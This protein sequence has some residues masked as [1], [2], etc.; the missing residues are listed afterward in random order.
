MSFVSHRTRAHRQTRRRRLVRL[1]GPQRWE[2]LAHLVQWL[3]SM[4]AHSFHAASTTLSAQQSVSWY[5]KESFFGVRGL[6]ILVTTLWLW[7]AVLTRTSRS[8][9]TVRTEGSGQLAPRRHALYAVHRGTIGGWWT[10]WSLCRSSSKG[11]TLSCM[12]PAT[13]SPL[14]SPSTG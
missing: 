4:L 2:M 14:S 5:A 3:P 13:P 6:T 12:R 7:L 10:G 1:V 9:R 8:L 11:A